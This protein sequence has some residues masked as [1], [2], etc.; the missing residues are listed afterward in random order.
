MFTEQQIRDAI[1]KCQTFS[2]E[3]AEGSFEEALSFDDLISNL[4]FTW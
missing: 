1:N 4:P 3:Y 2:H